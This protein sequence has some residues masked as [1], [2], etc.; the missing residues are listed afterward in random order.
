MSSACSPIPTRRR[1]S[2]RTSPTRSASRLDALPLRRR[3]SSP[4]SPPPTRPAT[5]TGSGRRSASRRIS[6]I[7]YSYGTYLGAVYAEL[8]PQRTD[9]IVLDSVVH[10]RR[11]WRET[12]FAWGPA[13]EVAVVPFLRFAA[14]NDATYGLGDTPGEVRAKFFEL[15]AEIEQEPFDHPLT[16]FVD[17]RLFRE[18]VRVVLRNDEQFPT[19]ALI[20]QLVD[21]RG[22][23]RAGT[24]GAGGERDR[25]AGRRGP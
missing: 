11:I 6:Y 1:T 23:V 16:G 5:W 20:W 10:P 8:F 17:H 19:L 25:E 24:H 14:E 21:E 9:R 7:G 12:F 2:P 22:E 13:A 18:F 4:T 15:L 3:R